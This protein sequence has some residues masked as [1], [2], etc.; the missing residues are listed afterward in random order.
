MNVFSDNWFTWY[1]F[2]V[3]F[4]QMRICCLIRSL[5]V[6][7]YLSLQCLN[8]HSQYSDKLL[9]VKYVKKRFASRYGFDR[10]QRS[11]LPLHS[12]FR[13]MC[14]SIRHLLDC[15]QRFDNW[16]TSSYFEAIMKN[17]LMD[18]FRFQTHWAKTTYTYLHT[19]TRNNG[20]TVYTLVHWANV[21][22]K[23]ML[24]YVFTYNHPK[25]KSLMF[26]CF[27]FQEWKSLWASM[28]A[29]K[30]LNWVIERSKSKVPQN[31]W[32]FAG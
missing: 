31:L 6:F 25:R 27:I 18:Q 2:E 32:H 3:L 30:G 4:N 23:W 14:F 11:S 12:R 21:I 15:F 19:S 20:S 24:N 22:W 1:L 26:F 8:R 7:W 5:F 28:G 16:H 17:V 10:E 29:S 9:L 13:S